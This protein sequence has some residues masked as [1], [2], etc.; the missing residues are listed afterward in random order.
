MGLLGLILM[1]LFYPTEI[2]F[3]LYGFAICY[4]EIKLVTLAAIYD[5]CMAASSAFS[6]AGCLPVFD[7]VY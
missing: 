3:E 4:L 7:I 1:V 2:T 6:I 5:A